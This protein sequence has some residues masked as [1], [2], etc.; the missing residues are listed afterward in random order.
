[1]AVF[2]GNVDA[3]SQAHTRKKGEIPCNEA[4]GFPWSECQVTKLTASHCTR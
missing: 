1:M 2:I 4:I 3:V